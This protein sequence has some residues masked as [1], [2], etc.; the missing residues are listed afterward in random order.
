MTINRIT[1]MSLLLI[2]C[3]I[4][5]VAAV[6]YWVGQPATAIVLEP[7]S[8]QSRLQETTLLPPSAKPLTTS[9]FTLDQLPELSIP[10]TE[11]QTDGCVLRAALS[12]P[13]GQVTVTLQRITDTS[14]EQALIEHTGIVLRETQT[15][16]YRSFSPP[17]ETSMGALTFHT[18]FATPTELTGF[19]TSAQ[20]NAI[21]TVTIHQ[22]ARVNPE[23]ENHFWR[24]VAAVTID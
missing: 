22:V 16:T 24:I 10:K 11:E 4:V 18:A 7:N 14:L 13:N 3:T 20:Q 12:Q 17:L 8:S 5:L 9:C 23:V 1:K 21:V 19:F 15:E 2:P 6:V